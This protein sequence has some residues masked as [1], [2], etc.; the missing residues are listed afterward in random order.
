VGSNRAASPDGSNA[1]AP[2]GYRSDP[3]LPAF[4]DDRP[5]L[6]FDAKCMLCSRWADVVLRYDRS[7]RYRLLSAQSPL[8]HAL[9]VHYGLDPENY[10]TIILLSGGVAYFKAEGAIR[11]A[12]DLGFPW[13]LAGALRMLPRSAAD[14]LYD[15]LARNRFKLFGRRATC[16]VPRA[17]D[18]DRFIA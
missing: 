4:A 5:I 17:E 12:G 14:A 10:D 2:Y 18:R 7:G 8:G 3:R 13:S 16:Y 1:R 6:I 11:L 9:Y 15:W